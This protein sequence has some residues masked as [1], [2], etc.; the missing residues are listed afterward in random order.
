MKSIV[1]S[2]LYYPNKFGLITF[3]SLEDVMGR[4]G[5]RALLNLVNLTKYIENYPPDNFSKEFDFAEKTAFGLALEEMYGPRGGRG[6]A[7]RVGRAIFRGAIEDFGA[8]AGIGDIAFKVLPLKIKLRIALPVMAKNFSKISDQYTS[9]EEKDSEFVYT[10]HQC[11]DCWGRTG[12][13]KPI[14]FGTT[15]FLQESLK[16]IS[17]GHEFRVNESRC[18]AMG[19]EVCEFI[20]QKNPILLSSSQISYHV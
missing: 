15:G 12:A 6:L 13:D 2:G 20:I 7:L 11:G 10:V 19:D 16:W 17:G 9:I 3:Q 5:L 4:N 1:E 8:L 18:H 14:C